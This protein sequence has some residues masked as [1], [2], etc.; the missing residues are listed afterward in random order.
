MKGGN[1]LFIKVT[2]ANLVPMLINL[3]H[4]LWAIRNENTG[5][6]TIHFLNGTSVEISETVYDLARTTTEGELENV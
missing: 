3:A 6:A 2:D 4:I 5:G 1:R